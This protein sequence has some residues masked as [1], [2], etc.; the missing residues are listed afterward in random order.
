LR[1]LKISNTRR[2]WLRAAF[3]HSRRSA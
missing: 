1:R 3:F 2:R